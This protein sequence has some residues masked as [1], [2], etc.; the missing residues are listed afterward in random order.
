MGSLDR[1]NEICSEEVSVLGL[2]V[3]YEVTALGR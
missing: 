1:T 3:I 2:T